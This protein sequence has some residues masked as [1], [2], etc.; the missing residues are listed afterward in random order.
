MKCIKKLGYC[1][2]KDKSSVHSNKNAPEKKKK[3]EFHVLSEKEEKLLK[4]RDN[5]K[6]IRPL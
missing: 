5:I 1:T 6:T 2:G 4:T 3:E